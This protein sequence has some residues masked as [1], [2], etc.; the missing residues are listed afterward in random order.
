MRGFDKAD[1]HTM[2]SDLKNWHIGFSDYNRK[3]RK[4]E[5]EDFSQ[6]EML[7]EISYVRKLS[8]IYIPRIFT[9]PSLRGIALDLPL[10]TERWARVNLMTTMSAEQYAPSGDRS[11]CRRADIGARAA[12]SNIARSGTESSTSSL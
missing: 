2:R 4:F 8:G 12:T 1:A 3:K 7:S 9:K 5:G 11:G 10:H 6:I